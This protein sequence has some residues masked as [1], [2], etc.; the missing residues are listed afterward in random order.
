MAMCHDHFLN[1][2]Q[3]IQENLKNSKKIDGF[4]KFEEKIQNIGGDA[5]LSEHAR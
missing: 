5:R 3:K 2:N 4:R 1:K